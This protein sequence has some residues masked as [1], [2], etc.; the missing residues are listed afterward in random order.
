MELLR[1]PVYILR[2]FVFVSL[3]CIVMISL[4]INAPESDINPPQ[5]VERKY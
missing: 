1:L 5:N 4:G 3:G 2:Y